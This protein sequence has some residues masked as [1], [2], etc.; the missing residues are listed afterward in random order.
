MKEPGGHPGERK[1]A[2]KI[3]P[4]ADGTPLADYV[5]RRFTYH[6]R[7]EWLELIA[8]GR[9][10]L[11]GRPGE[12]AEPLRAGSLLEYH[13]RP[14]VEPEVSLDARAVFE[15][16][17]LLAMDKPA[18]LP[19]HPGG[20]FFHNTLWAVIK[21]RWRLEGFA[22]VNRIDRETSGLVLVAK[23]SKSAQECRNQ[24]LHR[25]VRKQYLVLVEGLFPAP[26]EAKG[27]LHPDEDSA[28]RKKR[29][30]SPVET[31]SF[32]LVRTPPEGWEWAETSFRP[33][34]SRNGVTAILAE[35]GTGRLHQ[36]RATLHSL[37]FPVV[38]DKIYGLDPTMFIRFS[39]NTL[40]DR[41]RQM[42]RIDR[43]A[44]HSLRL[45]IRHPA[46]NRRLELSAPVPETLANLMRSLDIQTGIP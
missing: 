38:G 37:G 23:D 22:F 17:W 41:D 40:D 3:P 39:T 5:A 6:S 27:M 31:I 18:G 19:C 32:D 13:P 21:K 43:Q 12:P 9:L 25:R 24:F 7:E 29:S 1:P 30:F 35:P 44:L 46:D 10:R 20:S 45:E 34:D 33:L 36:I 8:E 42:L 14:H 26:M 16:R 15:D 2:L 4:D 28:V 11:D